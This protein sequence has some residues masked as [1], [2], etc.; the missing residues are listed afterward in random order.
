MIRF[1]GF[2]KGWIARTVPELMP[3]G[4]LQRCRDLNFSFEG[5]FRSV[6]E[7]QEQSV[8]GVSS[9]GNSIQEFFKVVTGSSTITYR[10]VQ[11]VTGVSAKTNDRAWRTIDADVGGGNTTT[12]DKG[13]WYTTMT[14]SPSTKQFVYIASPRGIMKD[15]GEQE[16][17]SGVTCEVGLNDSSMNNASDCTQPARQWMSA[18][19]GY[20]HFAFTYYNS[21]T[22]AESYASG[23]S[24]GIKIENHENAQVTYPVTFGKAGNADYVK[25][26]RTL[27]STTPVSEDDGGTLYYAGKTAI[28]TKSGVTYTGSTYLTRT[29][30]QLGEPLPDV[31]RPPKNATI[32]NSWRERLWLSGTTWWDS[33]DATGRIYFSRRNLPEVVPPTY[34]ISVDDN[35]ALPQALPVMGGSMYVVT[36][37]GIHEVIGRT[38]DTFRLDQ[39]SS[40]VGT[41]SAKSVVVGNEGIYFVNYQGVYLYKYKAEKISESIDWMFNDSGDGWHTK[42]TEA[43]IDNARGAYWDDK[44]YLTIGDQTLVYEP[45]QKRWRERTTRFTCA[46][47]D[48]INNKLYVGVTYPNWYTVASLIDDGTQGKQG[49]YSPDF[50]TKSEYIGASKE[51]IPPQVQWVSKFKVYCDGYWTFYFYVDDTLAYTKTGTTYTSAVSRNTIYNFPDTLKGQTMYVRGVASGNSV[52]PNESRF[53]TME[54]W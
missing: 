37:K 36:Q 14:P 7:L 16:Y 38:A 40:T 50:I 27:Q 26:Y 47:T 20:Y 29:D 28:T 31:G 42:F 4:S 1:F 21:I 54:I 45:E 41:K 3:Q 25:F 43:N 53:Y 46:W 5:G 19:I 35:E 11:G 49:L 2:I 39:S 17:T 22:G 30:S 33:T 24:Y 12:N 15:T 23:I 18:T 32:L 13:L 44:Y 10:V 52:Q 9:T 51:G 6:R 8:T 48:V 34:W